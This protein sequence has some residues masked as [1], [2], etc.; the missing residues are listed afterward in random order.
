MLNEEDL[1]EKRRQRLMKAGY[2]ARIRAKAGREQDRLREEEEQKADQE[3]MK[4]DHAGW[5][6]EIRKS[7]TVRPLLFLFR[8]ESLTS[9]VQEL[10]EKIKERKKTKEQLSDR[11]S[12][13]AQNRMKSIA[14]LASDV[15]TGKKRKRGGQGEWIFDCGVGDETDELGVADDDFGKND[16]DW[17]VYRQIVGP[18]PPLHLE[19]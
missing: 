10:I 1:K 13:A 6:N 17:A 18:R 14:N 8:C 9:G 2:D 15:N 5:L 12:L 3:A 16:D 4:T 7:H 11:K 19:L